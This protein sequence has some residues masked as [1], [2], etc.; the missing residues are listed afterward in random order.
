MLKKLFYFVLVYL[1]LAG[2]AYAKEVNIY[3][4]RQS[5]LIEPLLTGFTETTGIETNVVYLS[6]GIA[7]KM[8]LEGS[9]SPVDLILTVDITR[10]KELKD[11]GLTSPAR[12]GVLR[13]KIPPSLRDKDNHWFALTERARIIYASVD[14]KRAPVGEVN[15][16]AD[17]AKP[18][19]AKRLCTR[20]LSH[21][22]NLGLTASLIAQNG[23]Q[24]TVAW[25][26]GIKNSL[27]RKPQGN[28]RA[29]IKAITG[30]LC[31]YALGNSY[32]YYLLEA[33]DI[34]WTENVRFITPEAKDG[35]THM[36]I[37]G[38]ALARYAPHKAEALK[39]MQFFVGD[40]AQTVYANTNNEIPV[41]KGIPSSQRYDLGDF[42]RQPVSILDVANNLGKAQALVSS[43]QIDL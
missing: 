11:K 37:S 34:K 33:E 17:L 13:R 42:D 31:D 35:G 6:S 9:N 4:Y 23:E 38:M 18:A 2:T 40:W 28:D 8:A 29:Q 26:A 1:S 14:P 5:F 30:G 36:N 12:S 20:P 15:S 32:Y 10:L 41:V 21:V 22:Y 27:A 3:S 39:L 19:L 25:L 7:E 43:S 16:Y 24:S